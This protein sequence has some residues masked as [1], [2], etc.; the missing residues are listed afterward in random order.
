MD[1]FEKAELALLEK[2]YLLELE[3]ITQGYI[4]LVETEATILLSLISGY[5]LVAHFIGDSLTRAQLLIFNVLYLFTTLSSLAVY[6]GHYQSIVHSVERLLAENAVSAGD[7]PVTGTPESAALLVLAYLSMI[8]ASL[9]FMW[10]VRHPS[11]GAN[12]V[13]ED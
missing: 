11:P 7:I 5:L 2:S 13:S 8:I 9:Y 1:E 3:S 6:Y 4:S 10:T 12:S